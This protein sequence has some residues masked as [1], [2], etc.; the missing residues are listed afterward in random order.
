M[1]DD[2]RRIVLSRRARFVSAALA[3]AGIAT[4]ASVR[5]D[6]G[7]PRATIVVKA[8]KDGVECEA[9]VTVDGV[10]SEQRPGEPIP[11]EPGDHI[12]RVG[13]GESAAYMKIHVADGAMSVP[14]RVQV[15]ST[16]PR[17]CLSPPPPDEKDHP[18]GCGCHVVGKD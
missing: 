14:I 1:T 9:L 18:K 7:P 11:V 17:P 16:P 8:E 10:A 4:V 12:V 13:C 2:A 15:G 6:G 3:S 5:A